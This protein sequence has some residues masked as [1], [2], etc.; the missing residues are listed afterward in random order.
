MLSFVISDNSSKR[1]PPCDIQY[2][3]NTV[4]SVCNL[5]SSKAEQQLSILSISQEG[6]V[7]LTVSNE[8]TDR[9]CLTYD[10]QFFVA[11][12]NLVTSLSKEQ[13]MEPIGTSIFSRYS[14]SQGWYETFMT[15]SL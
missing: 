14:V 3:N 1:S 10:E 4:L 11:L 15:F 9:A 6:I 8:V 5:N 13:S 12:T 2:N 7:A